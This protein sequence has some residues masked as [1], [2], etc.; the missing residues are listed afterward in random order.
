MDKLAVAIVYYLHS[1]AF[2]SATFVH[3]E[4]IANSVK[5]TTTYY[6][7]SNMSGIL[8][9]HSYDDGVLLK[10]TQKGKSP[11]Y[12]MDIARQS[13]IWV[14]LEQ[15]FETLFMSLTADSVHDGD[16]ID[17]R[18]RLRIQ[19]CQIAFAHGKDIQDSAIAAG[20]HRQIARFVPLDP[21]L[22]YHALSNLITRNSQALVVM[23]SVLS[24]RQPGLL[25]LSK[26][27]PCAAALLFLRN[28]LAAIN[29]HDFNARW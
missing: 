29:E 10:E 1:S 18:I 2:T 22:A 21:K 3:A 17:G 23:Q 11:V 27:I 25:D 19:F 4:A 13:Q 26:D 14:D 15:D 6:R 8:P 5:S 20:I 24:V 16:L 9:E 12:E 28:S 7:L